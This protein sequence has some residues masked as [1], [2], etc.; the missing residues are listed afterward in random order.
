[1]LD[2]GTAVGTAVLGQESPSICRG[3][4]DGAQEKTEGEEEGEESPQSKA[5]ERSG[6]GDHIGWS[7]LRSSSSPW[8]M[9]E[10]APRDIELI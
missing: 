10:C 8:R 5:C 7:E 1:M 9:P 3:G 2:A 6:V 4:R